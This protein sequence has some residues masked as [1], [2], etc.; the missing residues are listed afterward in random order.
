MKAT[1]HNMFPGT[2]HVGTLSPYPQFC[3]EENPCLELAGN[4]AIYLDDTDNPVLWEMFSGDWQEMM[5]K[6]PERSSDPEAAVIVCTLSK[7]DNSSIS[8][9]AEGY[10]LTVT[11]EK[12]TIT[13]QDPAGLFYGVQTLLQLI[14]RSQDAGKIN[15][16]TISD[17]PHSQNRWIMPDMGRAPFTMNLLKRLVR[18][19]GRLKYNGIHLHLNDNQLNPVKYKGTKLGSEN[20]SAFTMEEYSE[21][22]QYAAQYH[23]EIIPEIE[24][25]GHAGSILQHYPHLYGASRLHGLGPSFAMGDETMELLSMMFEQWFEI[26][27]DNAKVHVGLDEGNW[28]ILPGAD[29]EIY[30]KKN[31]VRL[32]YNKFHEV[33]EKAGKKMQMVMWGD[34]RVHIPAD[35]RNDIIV[36]PWDYHS[37][38]VI[39]ERLI[40]FWI[41]ET[42]TF[43]ENNVLSHPFISGAGCCGSSDQPNLGPTREWATQAK[44]FRN[45]LGIDICM[46]STNDMQSK[47]I[48]LFYAADCAWNPV[49]AGAVLRDE[50]LEDDIGKLSLY[51]LNWQARFTDM[52]QEKWPEDVDEFVLQNRY[53]RGKKFG[54]EYL[55]E[56]MPE[57]IIKGDVDTE[58]NK[59][60]AK[61]KT[62]MKRVMKSPDPMAE[63]E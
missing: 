50:Q 36:Q 38:E 19:C 58:K 4:T 41:R 48:L 49:H 55:P 46:W 9:P 39:S 47:M 8:L 43:A 12:I 27:P 63:D 22:I 51:L 61:P 59:D 24:T 60:T 26:M 42:K 28:N 29:P 32:I 34:P 17:W 13:G 18:M 2:R 3:R 56:W 53:C 30:N 44:D 21:L 7:N 40:N 62:N 33:A 45:C 54:T 5:D 25:W 14:A 37:S 20:P 52:S 1:D 11:G 6:K 15:Y 23:V 16:C 31:M 10:S 57:N 35:I